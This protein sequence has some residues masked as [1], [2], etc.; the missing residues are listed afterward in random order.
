LYLTISLPS[1][2][3]TPFLRAFALFF[4]AFWQ[5]SPIITT[6]NY[7]IM[8][9]CRFA[10]HNETRGQAVEKFKGKGET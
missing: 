6:Q 10:S 8:T 3:F 2:V 5:K 7:L 1:G 4:L 9:L